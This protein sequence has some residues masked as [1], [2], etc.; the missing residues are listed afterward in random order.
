MSSNFRFQTS[1]AVFGNL[2][3][4]VPAVDVDLS[5][6]EQKNYPSTSLDENRKEFEFQTDRNYYVD[7][8]RTYLALK[9]KIDKGCGYGNYNTKELKKSRNK[10]LKRY[11]DG[12]GTGGSSFRYSCEQHFALNFFHCLKRTPTISKVSIQM[13]SICPSLTFPVVSR[14]HLWRQGKF[15]L[16]RVRLWRVSWWNYGS[17]FVWTFFHK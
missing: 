17:A 2:G 15:A 7:L 5:S 6:Q 11:G 13:D 8:K 9:L 12:V 3:G 14:G 4:K 16:K 1:V 10:R